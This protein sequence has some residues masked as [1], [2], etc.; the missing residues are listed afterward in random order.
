MTSILRCSFPEHGIVLLHGDSKLVLHDMA[1]R[2]WVYGLVD[3]LDDTIL[4]DQ[5]V[6]DPSYGISYQGASHHR[7]IAN[8]SDP[9]L[10]AAWCI[11]AMARLLKADRAMYVCTREDVSEWWKHYMREA[12]M[13]IQ[14]SIVWD[15]RQWTMGDSAAD[16][17]RQTEMILIA[18][19]GRALLQPWNW[20]D[21]ESWGEHMLAADKLVKR[22][23]CLWSYPVPRDKHSQLHPTPKPPQIME[24]AM[25]NHSSRGDLVLDPFMGG[26]PVGVAAAR[27]GRKYFGIELEA[28]YFALAVENITAELTRLAQGVAPKIVRD[29]VA[30]EELGF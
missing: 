18:H 8:D 12:A 16:L 1:E 20:S 5:V 2:P 25:L 29:M 9:S 7:A 4:F 21:L 27:Q 22:D 30:E 6:T 15:K 26:G 3:T 13:R 17:R 11:P 23:T 28:D 24:R 19:T 10:I 14:T